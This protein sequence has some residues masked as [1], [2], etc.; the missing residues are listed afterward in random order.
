MIRTFLAVSGAVAVLCAVIMFAL[1]RMPKA[2]VFVDGAGQCLFVDVV[3]DDEWVRKECGEFDF[4]TPHA[5]KRGG[6]AS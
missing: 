1:A 6:R 3:E 4:N 2:E 5:T